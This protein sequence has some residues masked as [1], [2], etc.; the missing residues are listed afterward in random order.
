[1]YIG[2]IGVQGWTLP[3]ENPNRHIVDSCEHSTWFS[4]LLSS[5]SQFPC[6]IAS[7]PPCSPVQHFLALHPPHETIWTFTW[8]M[9]TQLR[10]Q[11]D[12][13]MT[14]RYINY[15][16]I[17]IWYCV[18]VHI[19]VQ[20]TCQPLYASIDLLFHPLFA[21][22]VTLVRSQSFGFA[23]GLSIKYGTAMYCQTH[24]FSCLCA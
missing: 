1:M 11:S 15:G 23:L 13:N 3:N 6:L 18:I 4:T 22:H 14:W 2:Y 7:K 8:V 9:I 17:C 21:M 24:I 10:P 16:Y 19:N 12:G 5:L 20:Y